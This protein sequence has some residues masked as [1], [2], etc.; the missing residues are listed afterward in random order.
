MVFLELARAAPPRGTQAAPNTDDGPH[1]QL[2]DECSLAYVELNYFRIELRL[3]RQY[4]LTTDE[5][6]RCPNYMHL[7]PQQQREDPLLQQELRVTKELVAL[8]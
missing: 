4:G 7:L 5:F 2:V 3:A 6:L 8:L 1:M